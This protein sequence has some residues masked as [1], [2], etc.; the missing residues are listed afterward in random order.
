MIWFQLGI[1]GYAGPEITIGLGA[2]LHAARSRPG[3][4][5]DLL[6][7][8]KCHDELSIGEAPVATVWRI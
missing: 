4:G 2:F 8:P 6:F 5:H 7:L 1:I 3:F